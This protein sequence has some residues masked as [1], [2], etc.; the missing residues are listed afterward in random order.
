MFTPTQTSR[1]NG[2]NQPVQ[3]NHTEKS[4]CENTLTALSHQ[5]YLVWF[6]SNLSVFPPF[7]AVRLCETK[8]ADRDLV[9]EIVSL[10]FQTNSG[11]VRLWWNMIWPWSALTAESTVHFW[12][13]PD[14]IGSHVHYGMRKP[15]PCPNNNNN[16]NNKPAWVITDKR[17]ESNN[18]ISDDQHQNQPLQFPPRCEITGS[19]FVVCLSLC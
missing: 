16:N 11:A 19:G 10:R 1:T 3:F 5:P 18:V 8:Q 15:F 12:T 6:E 9:E 2:E 14:H 17:G 7:G 4:R 13:N